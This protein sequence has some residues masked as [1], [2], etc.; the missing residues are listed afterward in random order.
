[1]KMFSVI[2][3]AEQ[4]GVS[5]GTIYA[6]CARK[7]LRHERVGLGRGVIRIPDDAIAEYRRLHTVAIEAGAEEPPAPATLVKSRHFRLKPS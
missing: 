6:L 4:L 5:V 3:A 2:E 7:R 1:M